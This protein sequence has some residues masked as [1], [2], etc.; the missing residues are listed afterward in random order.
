MI[1]QSVLAKKRRGPAPTGKGQ[2]IVVRV[3]PPL[4]DPLDAW[5]ANQPTPQP[6]RPEAIRRLLARALEG[7]QPARTLD[8]KIA[9][10]KDRMASNPDAGDPTPANGMAALRRGLAET[11][12]RSLKARR[13]I[14]QKSAEGD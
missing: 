13:R 1:G 4:L 5:I 12:L 10:V 14:D 9:T 7:E 11:K 2:Q 3:H 8:Q 6:S